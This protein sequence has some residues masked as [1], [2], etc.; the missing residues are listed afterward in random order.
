MEANPSLVGSGDKTN[1]YPNPSICTC[2][3]LQRKAG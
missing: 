2:R 3:L 1:S